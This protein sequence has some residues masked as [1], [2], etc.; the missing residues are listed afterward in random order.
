MQEALD[1][2]VGQSEIEELKA[3]LH[4]ME[5]RY[6]SLLKEHAKIIAEAQRAIDKKQQIE[7]KYVASMKK[8]S[9]KHKSPATSNQLKTS[10]KL[11]KDNHGKIMK[12]LQDT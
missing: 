6:N 12:S 7:I 1:P 3:E 5:L 4:R 10:L 11:I 9:V 2:N 8:D